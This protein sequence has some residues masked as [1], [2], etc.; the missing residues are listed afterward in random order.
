MSNEIKAYDLGEDGEQWMVE[1]TL[2]EAVARRFYGNPT[3]GDDY[4]PPNEFGERAEPMWTFTPREDWYWLPV[5]SEHPDEDAIL[6]SLTEHGTDE[7]ATG[8]MFVGVLVI[9]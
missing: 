9:L 3:Q 8:E 4:F 5:N 6:R 2:D 1:G 7:R